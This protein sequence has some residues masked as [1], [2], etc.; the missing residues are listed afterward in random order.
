MYLA[1]SLILVSQSKE[2]LLSLCIVREL[3]SQRPMLYEY[4]VKT[5]YNEPD[6]SAPPGHRVKN[7][8]TMNSDEIKMKPGFGTEHGL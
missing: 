3:Y 4:M 6:K 1:M 7:R 2:N 5:D 8:V